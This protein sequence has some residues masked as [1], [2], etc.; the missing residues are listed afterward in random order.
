MPYSTFILA[1]SMLVSFT[2]FEPL[3][4]ANEP[5]AVA[6]ASNFA[7]TTR[8][9]ATEFE[10][11]SGTPVRISSASTGKLYAQIT[12]GAPFDV[13]LAADTKRPKF[14]ED[15]EHAAPNSRFTY[16]LGSLVL[17]SRDPDL[18][19]AD[20]KAKL[21]NLGNKRLAIA[22]PETAPYGAAAQQVLMNIDAW[23]AAQPQLV[24]G[25]NIAQTLLFVSTGNAS[26]GFI[27]TTQ[28]LDERLPAST[29]SWDVP[30][31]LHQPI[32]HQAI[33]LNRGNNPAAKAFLEFLKS[34]A[35]LAII[36]RHGYT[37]PN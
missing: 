3:L 17:W 35:G 5:V 16:A 6:V 11:Q 29:C 27:S 36:E 25:A 2:A 14:L 4:A 10:Q 7:S 37:L 15:S 21:S 26:L 33:L 18:E 32:A 1:V 12:N 8:E 31:N 24:F 23:G 22:N 30:E 9:L 34:P 13:F 20:C 19:A 28:A